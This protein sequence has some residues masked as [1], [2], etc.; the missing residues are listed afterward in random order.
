[1]SSKER[2][3]IDLDWY[4][5][6]AKVCSNGNAY[7]EKY[8]NDLF[9]A[10]RI[11]DDIVDKDYPVKDEDVCKALYC[12]A[13]EIPSNPFFIAN[14]SVLTSLHRTAI[15]N[16]A[17]CIALRK[18]PESEYKFDV[19]EKEDLTQLIGVKTKGEAMNFYDTIDC[20]IKEMFGL[21]ASITGGYD[22]MRE[23]SLKM[24]CIVREGS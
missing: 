11:M 20:V 13:C 19:M 2:R 6:A 22:F 9:F 7:A 21:V 10:M 18:L 5:W 3:H 1:V 14:V 23:I 4:R 24:R 16:W 12:L 8:V 15:N 17:D